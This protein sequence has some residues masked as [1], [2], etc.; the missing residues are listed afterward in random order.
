MGNENLEE[1]GVFG[2]S[3]S[4]WDGSEERVCDGVVGGRALG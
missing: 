3:K 2:M 4:T 1:T